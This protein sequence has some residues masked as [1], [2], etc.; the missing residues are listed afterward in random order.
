M[1]NKPT[2]NWYKTILDGVIKSKLS[3]KT[4]QNIQKLNPKTVKIDWNV[5]TK[6]IFDF[7]FLQ[8]E[9]SIAKTENLSVG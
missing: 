8:A 4:A 3:F 1:V 2:A 5:V 7:N 6:E 9:I